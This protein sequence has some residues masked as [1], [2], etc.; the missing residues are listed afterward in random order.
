M[1]SKIYGLIFQNIWPAGY[2]VQNTL[3]GV[4]G[5]QEGV[6]DDNVDLRRGVTTWSPS[7]VDGD[8]AGYNGIRPATQVGRRGVEGCLRG[9]DD[10]VSRDDEGSKTHRSDFE[11]QDDWQCRNKPYQWFHGLSKIK[12]SYSPGNSK[13]LTLASARGVF[14][15]P[16]RWK[17]RAPMTA[18]PR[19]ND[20]TFG[21]LETWY[22]TDRS[23]GQ[24]RRGCWWWPLCFMAIQC[25]P[26]TPLGLL[27]FSVKKFL[28]KSPARLSEWHVFDEKRVRPLFGDRQNYSWSFAVRNADWVQQGENSEFVLIITWIEDCMSIT[29]FLPSTS[30]LLTVFFELLNMAHFSNTLGD[31]KNDS[32]LFPPQILEQRQLNQ[33]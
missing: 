10:G 2:R 28:V 32:D 20:S 24:G 12:G 4:W 26:C 19:P 33:R 11:R 7:G 27:S 5:R 1:F 13:I 29:A 6:N 25:L 9:H 8:H 14:C 17:H 16:R 18:S 23:R 3:H 31:G 22:G 15:I 30:L 21:Q